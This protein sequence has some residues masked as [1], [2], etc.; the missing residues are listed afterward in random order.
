[1]EEF[2]WMLEPESLALEGFEKNC[3][4]LNPP[5]PPTSPKP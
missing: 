5:A 4:P 1:M 2:F 3:H